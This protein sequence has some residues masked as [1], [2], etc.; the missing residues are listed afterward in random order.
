MVEGNPVGWFGSRKSVSPREAKE[1]LKGRAVLV[2]VRESR[3]WRAGHVAGALHIPLAKL[4]TSM[5]RIPKNQQVLVICQSGM[6]S[7]S[8]SSQLRSAGFDVRNVSGGMN[9]W[10]RQVGL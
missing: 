7:R 3:E 1:L 5:G 8:A 10:T 2:D 4:P 9:A 6:R